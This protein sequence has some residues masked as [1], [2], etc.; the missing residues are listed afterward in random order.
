MS[1][2]LKAP[3]N[4]EQLERLLTRVL[5]PNDKARLLELFSARTEGSGVALILRDDESVRLPVTRLGR[6]S[7]T[8]QLNSNS[9]SQ[10]I[11]VDFTRPNWDQQ[12][13]SDI[14]PLDSA[15]AG[16]SALS[17]LT[18][19]RTDVAAVEQL[20]SALSA[21][22]AD[23]TV[24]FAAAFQG[25]KGGSSVVSNLPAIAHALNQGELDRKAATVSAFV[26]T[27]DQAVVK[28]L[29]GY[30]DENAPRRHQRLSEI[31][32]AI[33]EV[34]N[35]SKV[36]DADER[37]RM[38][39]LDDNAAAEARQMALKGLREKQSALYTETV[40]SLFESIDAE[41]HGGNPNVAFAAA[42]V[43]IGN[44]FDLTDRIIEQLRSVRETNLIRALG[45]SEEPSA[46]Q[47]IYEIGLSDTDYCSELA[48]G[49]LVDQVQSS[50]ELSNEQE[51]ALVNYAR[52]FETGK[53]PKKVASALVFASTKD[54]IQTL[55]D[56]KALPELALLAQNVLSKTATSSNTD[57]NNSKLLLLQELDAGMVL[58]TCSYRHSYWG[59]P[60][61]WIPIPENIE[62]E[63]TN[64]V[65]GASLLARQNDWRPEK[66]LETVLKALWEWGVGHEIGADEYSSTLRTHRAAAQAILAILQ[67]AQRTYDEPH[68]KKLRALANPAVAG[69]RPW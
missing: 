67:T 36:P 28:L 38:I 37:L 22:T 2:F 27:T 10:E 64:R 13:I 63:V 40:N 15:E 32:K 45:E 3:S 66:K 21:V 62:Q 12:L 61:R 43:L 59:P 44:H 1:Q 34:L 58:L 26:G 68:M 19:D 6:N 9:S 60:S 51:T 46:K 41:K 39:T 35:T 31:Q 18:A 42:E 50:G 11:T 16:V 25:T 55:I 52:R 17:A 65:A 7:I 49:L 69:R 5:L 57:V 47:A 24:E 33:L 8:L 29:C 54:G 56:M 30:L 20:R 53:V 48:L 14:K 23:R 4:P